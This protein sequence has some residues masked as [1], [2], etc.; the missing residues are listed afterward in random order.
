MIG[1][2][3]ISRNSAKAQNLPLT[4]TS[5]NQ[6][7]LRRQTMRRLSWKHPVRNCGDLSTVPSVPPFCVSTGKEFIVQTVNTGHYDV[8]SETDMGRPLGLMADHSSALPERP[9]LVLLWRWSRNSGRRR[10]QRHIP[11]GGTRR[12]S[13]DR[14]VT[15]PRHQGHPD[16]EPDEVHHG[17]DRC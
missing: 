5:T 9:G 6:R 7:E 14:T 13:E 3:Q 16:R 4:L 12:N 11:E 8:M 10:D 1:D 2:W 17:W 15:T